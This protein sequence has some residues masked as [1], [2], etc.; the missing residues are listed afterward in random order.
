VNLS[1]ALVVLAITLVS[2]IK[3]PRRL[4][5]WLA[6]GAGALLLLAVGAISPRAAGSA[7]GDLGPTVAFLAALLVLSEGCRRQQVFQTLG[8]YMGG[9][10]DGRPQRLFALVFA[11]STAVTVI[12][13]LDPTVVLL[14]PI[15]LI[16]AKRLR[17][18]PKPSAY[19][20]AHLA[21]SASLLLPISNLTNLLAFHASH[22]SFTRFAA[23]MA[24]PW[25]VAVAVEWLVLRHSFARE[26]SGAG[27]HRDRAP[28]GSVRLPADSLYALAVLALTLIGFGLSSPLGVAPLWMAVGGAALMIGPSVRREPV[29]A[30]R[31]LVLA[32]QPGFLVF[33]ICLGVI[34]RAAA[35]HGLHSAVVSLLPTGSSL[36]DLILVALLAAVAANL[37]NN[38]PATLILVPAAGAL[39]LGPLLA[40]LVG[41]NIGPNLTYGG[42]LATL[43]W[44]RIVHPEAVVV[45]LREF[46]RLGLATAL[47]ALPLAAAAVWLSVKLVA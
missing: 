38:L 14:T 40:V 25:A 10:A 47:P 31:G 16:T 20:C 12:L 5:E 46:T 39:G 37:L 21:N 3:R 18:D 6:G 7:A 19:A 34:V 13:G 33:V 43:L 30:T 23:I 42:S 1:L 29:R 4:P 44:R 24:L 9:A 2:A 28:Q 35:D 36:P 26:L 32:V 11:A 17:A 45:E 15:A 8:R 27:G 22:L 41:V